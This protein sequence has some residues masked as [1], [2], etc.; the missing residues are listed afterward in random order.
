MIC[1]RAKCA[2]VTSKG[3][4]DGLCWRCRSRIKRGAMLIAE[5]AARKMKPKLGRPLLGAA[6]DCIRCHKSTEVGKLMRDV[7]GACR[8]ITQAGAQA[9]MRGTALRAHQTPKCSVGKCERL[10]ELGQRT[11]LEH[12]IS[13]ERDPVSQRPNAEHFS[14][15]VRCMMEESDG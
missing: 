12:R 2:G 14:R 6:R 7:C 3:H 1:K 10:M 13:F 9:L 4:D 15:V 8:N 5:R 11:C